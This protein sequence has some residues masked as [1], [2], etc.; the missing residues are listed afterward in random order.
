[1]RC[2]ACNRGLNDRESVR[3]YASTG[4]FVDLCNKCFSHVAEDIPD[5]DDGVD[6][7]NG[8]Y[9]EVDETE[10]FTGEEYTE[11]GQYQDDTDSR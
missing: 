8:P 1:M 9:V 11:L 7:V 3:K 4:S 5:V 6:G 2:L 10:T